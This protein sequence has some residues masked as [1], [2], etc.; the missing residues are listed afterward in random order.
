M[1]RSIDY[2]FQ[3]IE[4]LDQPSQYTFTVSY[5]E[6]YCEKI[7]DSLNPTNINLKLRESLPNG[8]IVPDIYEVVCGSV[9]EILTVMETGKRNRSVAPTLMNAASSRSHTIFSLK[10]EQKNAATRSTLRSRLYMIDLA[11]SERVA[12]TGAKGVKLEEAKKINQSLSSLSMVIKALCDCLV[13]V[14]YRNS[15]LTKLLMDSL[16]G[17]SRTALII[18]CA[19]EPQFLPESLS[20]LRF[21]DRAKR[22]KNKC[23]VS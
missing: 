21:G 1:P 2:I 9:D 6:I 7:R 4:R 14:P 20:T 10:I 19:P 22:V 15:K 18:C 12:L 3:A 17:N 5:F 16:G 8:F 13:H 11:G 23:A